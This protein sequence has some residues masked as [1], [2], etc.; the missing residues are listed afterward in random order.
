MLDRTDRPGSG[1]TPSAVSRGRVKRTPRGANKDQ[2]LKED[3]RLVGRL[4][5]DTFRAQ[6]GDAR[7]QA[8][9]RIRQLAVRFR[10]DRD[11]A[12]R[13]ELEHILNS[14][15]LEDSISVVRVFSYF[16]HLANLAEDE[17]HNRRRRF[18]RLAGSKPQEGSIPHAITRLKAA[19]VGAPALAGF[20]A[21]ALI[22]P[23]LTA[24]PTE[25]QRKST[26]DC[27]REVARLLAERDRGPL[28]DEETQRLHAALARQVLALWQTRMLRL[29]KLRVED[30]IENALAYYRRTFLAEVPALVAD[31][32]DLLDEQYPTRERWRLPPILR[33]GSW[34]GGDRDGNPFVTQRVLE[35]AVQRQ[36]ILAFEHY[37]DEVHALGGELA[38]SL[39]MVDVTPALTALA[40][41]AHDRSAHRQDEPYRQALIGIYARLAATTL[42]LNG[43]HP[44]RHAAAEAEPYRSADEFVADLETIR[45]SLEAN[46]GAAL[47]D[48]RLRRLLVAARTFRFSLAALDLRQNSDV[49]ERVVAELL[50]LASVHPAYAQADETEKERLLVAELA[51]ARPLVSPF[52]EYTDE[53][54]GE[55]D[56]LQAAS[57]I[58]ARHGR[59]ALPHYIISKTT[60]AS[61][62]LEVALLAREAGLFRPGPR[63][64]AAMRIIP[65]FETIADLRGCAAITQRFLSMPGIMH[66]VRES[67]DNTLEVMLGYSDSNKDGGFLTSTWELYNAEVRLSELLGGLDV[68]LRLFHGRGGSVGRGGGPTYQAIVAQPAGA[69]SGQIRITEQG[70]VIAGKYANREIGRRNLETLVAA[71]M[72]ATLAHTEPHGRTGR[73]REIMDVLSENAY[74]AYRTLVYETPGFTDYFRAAT[75]ITEIAEL[76]IGSR[77]ASRK[78]SRRIEDLRA[79]PWVFSWAQSRVLLPGW[80]G[81]GS[82]VHAFVA[83]GPKKRWAELREMHRHW[84]FFQTLLANM[85][86]VL[87][88]TDLGIASRY[89]GLVPDPALRKRVFTRI[90]EEWHLTRRALLAITGQRDFLASNPPLARAIKNRVPYIDPLNHL[91]VELVRRFRSGEQSERVQRGIHLTINGIAAGLRNS[92]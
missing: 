55:L 39:G 85:D 92:G 40:A 8:V 14:L 2:P 78:P 71:T 63:P 19:G 32:E 48:G 13:V 38:L 51:H 53:T 16:S 28:T 11:E 50:D 9:E 10:R 22:S 90:E 6:E 35:H 29:A 20:F 86:M 1:A 88:K 74:R 68:R 66:V 23:V 61:D 5:G 70:E 43:A 30:E 72:E 75:P 37:L 46:R 7:F 45:E 12:A 24:H 41:R 60:A 26:L 21:T 54:R 25:V 58:Q 18:H 91:Q 81:F 80:F 36:S 4:L 44:L 47:A 31:L 52:V 49:H 62:L 65:L 42:A 76:N 15:E 34:I 27:E 17:H 82:G 3:I 89:A 56:L 83:D 57:A 33:V 64:A 73:F 79:I 69:V 67:W 59:D 77:P 84:P 87:A